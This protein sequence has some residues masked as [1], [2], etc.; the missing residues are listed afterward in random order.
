MAACMQ[1]WLVNAYLVQVHA[2]TT[3]RLLDRASQ[4]LQILLVSND[5]ARTVATF[6]NAIQY[7]YSCSGQPSNTPGWNISVS[8]LDNV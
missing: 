3:D 1:A 2:G 4:L 5:C 8:S 7:S 6:L